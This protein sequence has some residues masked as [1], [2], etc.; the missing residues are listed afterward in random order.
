M[1]I[2]VTQAKQLREKNSSTV[3][4]DVREAEEVAFC[5][6]SKSLHIPLGELPKR[7]N[8]LPKDSPL[9]LYCHHGMRSLQ[10]VQFLRDKGFENA[11]NLSGGIHAWSLTID[12]SLPTY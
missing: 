3:F 9:I 2:T 6:I 7:Y 5:T 4:L 12:P 8:H 10:A 1:E 11:I